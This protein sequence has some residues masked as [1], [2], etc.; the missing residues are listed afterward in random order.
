MFNF[1]KRKKNQSI[2]SGNTNFRKVEAWGQPSAGDLL[3]DRSGAGGPPGDR[4]G[5]HSGDGSGN[6]SGNSAGGSAHSPSGVTPGETSSNSPHEASGGSAGGFSGNSAKRVPVV[7]TVARDNSQL[8]RGSKLR[9]T[10]DVHYNLDLLKALVPSPEM[11]VE[12]ISLGTLAP[13]D[14]LIVYLKNIANPRIVAE[15]KQRLQKIK[16]RTLYESSYIQRN[17]EDSTISPFP[18]V[19][20]NERPDVAVSALFQGRV[21]II[22]DGSPHVLLAPCTFFDLMDTPDD[23]YNRWFLSASFFKIARFMMLLSAACLPGF[24]IALLSYNQELIPTRLLLLILNSRENT[25][26]PVY[27]E[28]FV[29]MGVS[30]ALRLMMLRI[31]SVVG[32]TIALFAG[33]TLVIA[34]LLSHIIGAPVLVVVTLT[35][36]SSFGIPDYDL[37]TSI[38]VLQFFTM[39]ISSFLGL[40]GFAISFLMICIHLSTLTSFGI[41]YMAPLATTEFAGWSHTLFRENS[42][43]MSVDDTYKPQNPLKGRNK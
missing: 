32:S 39:V 41:P 20:S 28:L 43:E 29:L 42:K 4:S 34:G 9:F 36:L 24:Y 8:L 17:I 2:N 6:P 33:I 38:R 31:P 15:V 1:L 14:V 19:E 40:F 3:R 18:Q 13:K 5:G 26:F 11:A 37:R 35:A 21:I 12:A 22:L 27:F 30:E 23:A 16:A 10:E 7:S 25:P